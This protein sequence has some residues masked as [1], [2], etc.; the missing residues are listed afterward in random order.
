MKL[1]SFERQGKNGFGLVTADGQ[2]VIDL[3]AALGK[4]YADL[5]SLLQA[6]AIE[7][8]RQFL[9]READ[10][11]FADA[12]LLP[13][14]PNPS[15]IWCVGLNY[16]E[17]V[18]ETGREVT[19]QP[20]FFLRVADSQVGH[21]EAIPRPPESVTLDYE[22][23]IAII[24]GKPGR[25]ISEAD[26]WDHIA[27]YACYND[28]SVR[29]WQM[30]TQQW[31]PGKNFWRTGAFGPW[32]VTADEIPAGTVMTLTTRL[33]GVEVQRATTEMMLHDIPRQIAYAS[34]VAPLQAGDVIVTGT[35]GGI[36]AKRTPP[37]WMKAGDVVE[38]E[39]DRIGVLRNSIVDER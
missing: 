4:R 13:V 17:H 33:N 27:G 10:F 25:R 35:P 39:V 20:V 6:D 19:E 23:E 34:T 26:A 38:V 32:M 15:K 22:G 1:V 36:G 5:Q 29:Q 8:A 28:A 18:R 30:H 2:G 24:I 31:C 12:K 21:G 11:A 3:G 37:L 14:I 7:E 9:T 16:G